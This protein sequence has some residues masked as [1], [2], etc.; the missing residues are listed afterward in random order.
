MTPLAGSFLGY[1]LIASAFA[2]SIYLFFTWNKVSSPA[3]GSLATAPLLRTWRILL[4]A[5]PSVL[6]LLIALMWS[7]YDVLPKN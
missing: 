2:L 1:A 7:Y 6:L 4:L 3:L 5:V